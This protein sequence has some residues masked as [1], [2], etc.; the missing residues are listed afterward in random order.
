[1]A[2]TRH[3]ANITKLPKLLQKRKGRPNPDTVMSDWSD[4]ETNEPLLADHRNYFK[5]EKWTK[6]G[7]IERMLYAGS[8]LDKARDIFTA[9]VKHRPRIRLTIRQWIRVL[10]EWPPK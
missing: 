5:V 7:R 1:M 4:E 9:A 2:K 10:Q 6:A 3:D 8:N